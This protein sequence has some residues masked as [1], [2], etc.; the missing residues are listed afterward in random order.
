MYAVAKD[1]GMPIREKIDNYFP[2]VIKEGVLRNLQKDVDTMINLEKVLA[3]DNLSAESG[4]DSLIKRMVDSGVIAKDIS[5]ETKQALDHL[6][7]QLGSYSLAFESLRKGINSER[8]TINKHLEKGREL[9][10]PDSLLERDARVVIPDY[11]QRWA[12]RVE[13]VKAFG[14]EG[15]KMFGNINVLQASGFSNEARVLRDTF[16]S[17]T[18]LSETKLEIIVPLQR[19]FGTH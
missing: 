18:N 10:L 14:V 8:Y 6:R 13:Y 5:V 1:S 2:H 15:E 7:G 16:D 12:K 3:K 11:V 4:M 17:F 19:I 9:D